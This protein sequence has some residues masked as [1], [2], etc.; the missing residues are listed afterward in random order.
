MIGIIRTAVR[1][2]PAVAAATTAQAQS[3]SLLAAMRADPWGRPSNDSAVRCRRGT[4]ALL[5]LALLLL[6][7]P[8]TASAETSSLLTKDVWE[9]T[10]KLYC[11]VA[12]DYRCP[13]NRPGRPGER[14]RCLIQ[15]GDKGRLIRWGR[16]VR[17]SPLMRDHR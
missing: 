17:E 14:C 10:K 11:R 7:V 9:R 2:T 3:P 16:I 5:L 1:I 13:V 8:T 6:S 12:S 4:S 15:V